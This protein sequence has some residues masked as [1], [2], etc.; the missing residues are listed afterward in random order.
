MAALVQSYTQP[1][2]TIT[3]LPSRPKSASGMLPT[4]PQ[5]FSYG[6][7]RGSNHQHH[8]VQGNSQRPMPYRAT[9][10]PVQPYA[11]TSTPSLNNQDRQWQQSRTS[12]TSSMPS[13]PTI[14]TID[15][16]HGAGRPRYPAGAPVTNPPGNATVGFSGR[17]RDDSAIPAS[18]TRRSSASPRPQSSHHLAASSPT[19]LGLPQQTTTPARVSPERYRR[20]ASRTA[21]QPTTQPSTGPANAGV[22]YGHH[23]S[24]TD[25]GDAM[26]RGRRVASATRS[27]NNYAPSQPVRV[28][29]D[30]QLNYNYGREGALGSRRRSLPSLD[31]AS[32]P[33]F[34]APTD[35]R[36]LPNGVARGDDSSRPKSADKAKAAEREQQKGTR[37]SPSSGGAEKKLGHGRKGSAD[38]RGSSSGSNSRP[39]SV[40]YP[41]NFL[42]ALS[43]RI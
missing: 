17:S 6:A 8:A 33:K 15:S 30:L 25:P 19:T 35:N 40:S 31:I 29:D 21:E 10:V 37:L 26:A 36:V 27:N 20:P 41:C 32:L 2:G 16:D 42:F 13:V 3:L 43:P 4:Q 11:F 28:A 39:S 34:A 22:V 14:Q 24:P 18:G 23:R 7:P 12:R 9:P 38:S 5:Q 1:T